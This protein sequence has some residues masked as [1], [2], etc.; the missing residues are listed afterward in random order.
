MNNPA[1]A[2]TTES[3]S[4]T[5]VRTRM[6]YA[7]PLS[8]VASGVFHGGLLIT[9]SQSTLGS[10]PAQAIAATSKLDGLEWSLNEPVKDAGIPIDLALV[11]PPLTEPEPIQP[12]P[13][14]PISPPISPELPRPALAPPEPIETRLGIEE[15]AQKTESWLGF[16]EVTEHSAPFFELDQPAWSTAPGVPVPNGASQTSASEA[17]ASNTAASSSE[18]SSSFESVS[19]SNLAATNQTL[20]EPE[21]PAQGNAFERLIPKA[22]AADLARFERDDAAKPDL[23]ARESEVT[24][25]G[26]AIDVK[27]SERTLLDALPTQETPLVPDQVP[28]QIVP[29]EQLLTA[30]VPPEQSF[31]S[32]TNSKHNQKPTTGEIE[33]DL[34]TDDPTPEGLVPKKVP[35]PD[36]RLDV[37]VAD[38]VREGLTT[39]V[40]TPEA[41]AQDA[42][43]TTLHEEQ[44]NESRLAEL[45]SAIEDKPQVLDLSEVLDLREVLVAAVS[46]EA[47]PN[48][49]VAPKVNAEVS[50][51]AKALASSKLAEPVLPPQA[52]A[53]R[54]PLPIASSAPMPAPMT[55]A[56]APA[57][58]SVEPATETRE[59]AKEGSEASTREE[60]L[61]DP[62]ASA[63]V[64]PTKASPQQQP[65]AEQ[66]LAEQLFVAPDQSGQQSVQ[67]ARQ[68]NQQPAQQPN[69]LGMPVPLGDQPAERSVSDA[70]PTSKLPSINVKLG[71]P[72]AG[73]GLEVR[74]VRPRF[75]MTTILTSNPRKSSINVFFG[76][77]GRVLKAKFV[78]GKTTGY[79]DVDGPLLD[80]IYRWTARGKALEDVPPGT[81]PA[82][83]LLVNFNIEL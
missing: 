39:G 35:Q 78:E 76:R 70:S 11:P 3:T 71:R 69:Q 81:D 63:S 64:N 73:Q 83:G 38:D 33:Q 23:K 56:T 17:S 9:L 42:P 22:T 31:P 43:A 25:T 62:T 72:A 49:P 14:P 4:R 47:T 57:P 46:Q 26:A 12:P 18:V 13:L 40:R 68:P 28:E 65:A 61:T 45:K 53:T 80:A 32:T 55:V 66:P 5:K 7:L 52:E 21:K 44:I 36:L 15:S 19:P 2:N 50:I 6:S 75:S 79:D 60:A 51:D 16:A 59:G 67:Q 41:V 58:K 34:P 1:R 48:V 10:E 54:V 27:A 8:F 77:D 74:T 20:P 24:N 82:K 29:N 37:A 30:V